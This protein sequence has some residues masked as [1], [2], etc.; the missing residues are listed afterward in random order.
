MADKRTMPKPVTY[1]SD[2]WADDGQ[3]KPL[4]FIKGLTPK[5]EM[6]EDVYQIEGAVRRQINWELVREGLG[7]QLSDGLGDKIS[8]LVFR[9]DCIE[10]LAE[11]MKPV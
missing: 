5:P 9:E 1:P 7:G 8:A 2:A 3:L 4:V 6:G 10:L 11:R